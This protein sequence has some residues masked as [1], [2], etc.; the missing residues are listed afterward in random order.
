VSEALCLLC[1]SRKETVESP[2]FD[3]GHRPREEEMDLAHLFSS[4]HLSSDEL[5]AAGE[6][7]AA[8]ERPA[9]RANHREQRIGPGL[10]PR[11]L[12]LVTLGN[13][14][15]T[16]L[17]GFTCWWGWRSN[18]PSAARQVLGVTSVVAIALGLFWAI[19]VF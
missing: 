12:A 8:G 6:R 1:G 2:C 17:L 19:L 5:V 11:E 18:R 3:C 10:A 14:V 9:P 15:F 7:I 16:P 13:L 4:G